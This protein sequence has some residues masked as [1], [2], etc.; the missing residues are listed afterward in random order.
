[1]VNQQYQL[2]SL[3]YGYCCQNHDIICQSSFNCLMVT[4]QIHEATKPY[5]H[6][7]FNYYYQIHHIT[8][9]FTASFSNS[10]VLVTNPWYYFQMINISIKSKIL[11]SWHYYQIHGVTVKFRTFKL[12]DI[13]ITESQILL[14]NLCYCCRIQDIIVK[15]SILLKIPLHY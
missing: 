7:T 11:L 5:I 1:M 9:K 8:I 3:C 13:V 14:S 6:V 2:I 15:F 12:H 10:M 4:S